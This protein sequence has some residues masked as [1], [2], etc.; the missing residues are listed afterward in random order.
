MAPAG[1]K[2]IDPEKRRV[3]LNL[4]TTYVSVETWAYNAI[5]N[6]SR[7]TGTQIKRYIETA[8]MEYAKK[9]LRSRRRSSR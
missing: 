6:D 3:K 8:V 1:R 5:V 7:A 9:L 4:N 2:P